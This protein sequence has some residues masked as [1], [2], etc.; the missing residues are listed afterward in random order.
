MAQQSPSF[1]QKLIDKFS[2]SRD[3]TISFILHAILVAVF[4]TSV[5]FHAVQEP[6]DFAG[7]EDG[8]VAP[9][10]VNQQPPTPQPETP[11]LQVP[12]P[13]SQ[14]QTITTT[15][16]PQALDFTINP[17]V[18]QAPVPVATPSATQVATPAPAVGMSKEAASNIKAFSKGWGKSGGPGTG[19]REREFEFTAFIGQYAGGNWNSTVRVDTKA[20]VVPGKGTQIAA[21]SLPNLLYIINKWSK[22][23]IKTNDKQV[24]AIKL[25]TD[26]IFAIKPPFIFITGTKDFVL[27]DKE[28]SN[29]QKYVR[30]G[31]AIWGDSS[32]PGLRSRFDI[33]FR[34]EM[35]RVIPDVDKKFE[36]LPDN[37]PIYT[38]SY[39]KDI[40]GVQP[41]LN[42]YKLP[43]YALKIYG[44]IAI[45]YTANDYGDMWQ[46]GLDEKGQVDLR[47]G[48]G[49][50]GDYVAINPELWKAK[51]TYVH[52]LT[53]E[54]LSNAYK[55]GTNIIVHL[56][57]RWESKVA[58]A[59]SL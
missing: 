22:D 36:E 29:L 31:G 33:A 46:I 19:V 20:P 45:L 21:G 48:K 54:G 16:L 13:S 37:H 2:N 4:G 3:F 59:P 14:V 6:P 5:L 34:R 58:S 50:S 56:L 17:V 25:D 11:Q 27:S 52:N 12:P 53:P 18:M 49:G 44:E 40:K 41:G 26:E 7:G 43:I 42:F 57:T 28:V 9:S 30:S 10:S 23:K 24:R 39:W 35:K 51:D 38:N 47:T 1:L 32:V 55:L 15:A 8:I